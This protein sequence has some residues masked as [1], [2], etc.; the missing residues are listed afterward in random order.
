MRFRLFFLVLSFLM[1]ITAYSQLSDFKLQVTPTNETC[2]N[3]GNIQIQTS[4]TTPGATM[5]YS[6]YLQPD[7]T[8]PILQFQT[9]SLSGLNSGDYRLLATQTLGDLSNSQFEDFTIED[10]TAPVLFTAT[11]SAQSN[12][13]QTGTITVN[14]TSGL[15]PFFYEI[16][17]GPMVFPL[18]SSNV[19]SGLISGLY[20]V[21]VVD[22]CGNAESLDY[23][24]QLGSTG[25]TFENLSN[26][27]IVNSCTDIDVHTV[28][29]PTTGT[30]IVYPL[31]VRYILHLPGGTD[32]VIDLP[33]YTT[34]PED[35]LELVRNMPL[36]LTET[37][38]YDIIVTDSCGVPFESLGNIVDPSPKLNISRNP[39]PCGNV[40]L[41]VEANNFSPPYTLT[42]T[43]APQD[44]NPAL[45]NSNYPNSFS[46]INVDFGSD[47]L[48]VPEGF[49]EVEMLDSCGRTATGSIEV[50]EKILKPIV[51]D[52]G[53]G[54]N[55]GGGVVRISLPEARKIVSAFITVAPTAYVPNLPNNVTPFINPDTGILAVT[56]LPIGEYTFKFTD[57]CGKD[58]IEDAEIEPFVPEFDLLLSVLPGCTPSIASIRLRSPNAVNL[59]SLIV[60]SAPEG[61]IHPTPYDATS[62][63]NNG[64]VFM[65]DL[66]AGDYSFS[67]VDAC[68]LALTVSR[69]VD[70]YDPGTDNF[71]FSP[72]CGS[73]DLAVH[74]HS[75]IIGVSYWLQK[76][77][78]VANI[79][80]HPATGQDYA[81]GTTPTSANSILLYNASTISNLTYTGTFRIVKVY[82]T[83]DA[84]S[85]FCYDKYPSFTFSGRLEVLNV[86][87]LECEGGAGNS[88]VYIDIS[89]VP[90]YS[91]RI[92]TKDGA[93]FVVDN[94]SSTTFDNLAQG[95]YTIEIEDS[96][97]RTRIINVN[98]GTLLPLVRAVDP[99]TVGPGELLICS[100]TQQP[101]G[102]F[103]L[104][105]L[106]PAILGNQAPDNYVITYHTSQA[107]AN[108]GQ[109]PITLPQAYVNISNPQTIYVR[110]VHKTI[111]IC[112]D[113]TSFGLFVG[114]PPVLK[115]IPDQYV[116]EGST[117]RI[118]A[119][120]GYDSYEWS[121]GAKTAYIDV[122]DAG[123]YSVEVSNLYGTSKCSSVQSINVITSGPPVITSIEVNDWS[124]QEN[125]IEISVTG[126][127]NYVYS[128]DGENYQQ[129]NI[130]VGLIPGIYTVYV[131]DTQGCGL[132]TQQA[133]V[134]NYPKFF[135]PN[136]DGFNDLWQIKNSALEPDMQIYIYDRY[137][138]LLTG[139][140]AGSPG[141]DGTYNGHPM[142]STDYWFVVERANGT[143]H[144]GH[145]AMKR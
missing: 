41:T 86:Y 142:P 6:L 132:V 99:G 85:A 77:D 130:I 128:V 69:T 78:P 10:D 58:Y 48:F 134:F 29:H 12:C 51:S 76:L 137:G 126:S 97:S 94:G 108:S 125:S 17:S 36:Y 88:S 87:S 9:N 8:T 82:Q 33:P 60:E 75:S 127:G 64:T 55:G 15:G 26:A 35:A 92:L 116:C 119:D 40:Y 7:T 115:A 100:E 138:K 50:E 107:A 11:P 23:R 111:G 91:L 106:N 109:D 47:N 74:D 118:F 22:N 90:P 101:S 70:G 39:D 24:L 62:E 136:A 42:F 1:T 14:V 21:R 124:E 25:L 89:G 59:T 28:I 16:I 37:Y 84:G 144:R 68:G 131:K 66:P 72:Y 49:Y 104:T 73:F 113:T 123:S 54:C 2:V 63:I 105:L 98:V 32:Q 121:T 141:W 13:D 46:Q 81:E 102:I 139:F 61:F 110:L 117:I 19:F 67:A 79:W 3:N 56:G 93:P 65:S 140:I 18:Q 43:A 52:N 114:Q 31:S 5:S 112:Y 103:N 95:L 44:F 80:G 71:T 45:Y 133:L 38:T 96:C 4:D 34:G 20:R 120:S 129:S 57:E 53:P 143:V 83:Y 135:T 122:E 145:F 30:V 27:P